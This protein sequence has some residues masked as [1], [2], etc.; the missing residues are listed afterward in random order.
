MANASSTPGSGKGLNQETRIWGLSPVA[1]TSLTRDR[2]AKY[3]LCL[4]GKRA[5]PPE[6]CGG[7]WGYAEYQEAVGNPLHEQH[8][9]MMEGGEPFDS[10]G[11][12][13][14]RATKEMRKV[15]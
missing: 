8:D 9:E 2:K 10:D 4:A 6:D 14:K 13:A 3:P 11:F 1:P 15:K 7:P 5:C 12:D